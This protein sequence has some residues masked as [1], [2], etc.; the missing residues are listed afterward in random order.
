[1]FNKVKCVATAVILTVALCFSA[2]QDHSTSPLSGSGSMSVSLNSG[3]QISYLV[4]DTAALGATRIDPQL[5]NAWGISVSPNGTFWIS[6]NGSGLSSVYAPDGSQR[7]PAVQIPSRTSSNGGVPTGNIFNGTS[8]FA[9]P[10]GGAARF[11]FAGEDGIISAWGGGSSAIRVAVSKQPHGVYKGIAMASLN[12]QNYLYATDFHNARIDIFDKNY[13]Q[14]NSDSLFKDNQMPQGF[15]P[16][17]IQNIGGML[18]VSYAKQILPSKH[19][20][21]KGPG[22]GYVDIFNSNGKLVKRFASAGTL[23][24]PWGIAVAPSGFGSLSGAILVGNFGDGR[25]NAY[26]ADGTFLGQLSDASGNAIAVD[27]LWGIIPYNGILYF[28]AG[29]FDE[30]HGSFGNIHL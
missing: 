29:P 4:S 19:D 24:S 27:G 15:A 9:L 30:S 11:I 5:V 25:L 3:Y 1:M 28:A 18:Y 12:G 20:D 26:D 6:D 16:F 8:D 2:C 22:N 23:N 13:N 10:S 17:G 7:L 14:I 21:Q